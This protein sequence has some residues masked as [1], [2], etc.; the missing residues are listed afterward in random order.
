M[1]S[2]RKNSD[3]GSKLCTRQPA[4]LLSIWH[5]RV[6]AMVKTCFADAENHGLWCS[7]H[8]WSI[9]VI[10][11]IKSINQTCV[12]LPFW[13]WTSPP[14]WA[15]WLVVHLKR[16]LEDWF[17]LIGKAE[18]WLDFPEQCGPVL[19]LKTTDFGHVQ[20]INCAFFGGGYWL[21]IQDPDPCWCLLMFVVGY[22]VTFRLTWNDDSN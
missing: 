13:A 17:R 19:V 1:E 5:V 21:P 20:R 22:F 10:Y 2:F 16:C 4:C 12:S 9:L 7:H 18:F 8:T 6:S 14:H 11:T 15:K 3:G